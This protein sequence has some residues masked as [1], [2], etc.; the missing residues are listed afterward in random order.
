MDQNGPNFLEAPTVQE[1][2]QRCAC[3]QE[4][5]GTDLVIRCHLCRALHHLDCYSNQGGCAVFAC[6][7]IKA[8]HMSGQS[9]ENLADNVFRAELQQSVNRWSSGDD[10]YVVFIF[11]C[12]TGA[13][14]LF[15]YL[16]L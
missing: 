7:N 8:I 11:I 15:L 9:E 3:C 13:F 12:I 1:A 4:A 6:L 5:T 14:F 16:L 2:V 10:S